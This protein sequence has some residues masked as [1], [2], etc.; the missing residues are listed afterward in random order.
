M[1]V[2]MKVLR[3]F[4]VSKNLYA[5]SRCFCNENLLTS[6][7]SLLSN[8]PL[9]SLG[10]WLSILHGAAAQVNPLRKETFLWIE[11]PMLSITKMHNW[12]RVTQAV[13]CDADVGLDKV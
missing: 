4:S 7:L 13:D 11:T 2:P 10:L 8:I 9:H 1:A 5:V 3:R 12:I 6:R